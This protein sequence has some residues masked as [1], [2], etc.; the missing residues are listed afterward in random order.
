MYILECL[1]KLFRKK[2][3]EK[4]DFNYNPLN[5]P[6]IEEEYERC[7]HKF[8]PLDSSGENLACI[9]CGFIVKRSNIKEVD[10]DSDY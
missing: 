9:K 2:T 6:Y 10:Y 7:N 4:N 8:M 5:E 3:K 1:F